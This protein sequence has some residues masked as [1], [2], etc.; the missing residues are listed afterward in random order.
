MIMT[1]FFNVLTNTLCSNV[2]GYIIIQMLHEEFILFVII[3]ELFY[4]F[5]L[6]S[7]V[8]CLST[9]QSQLNSDQQYNNTKGNPLFTLRV[10]PPPRIGM[11]KR[12]PP[13]SKSSLPTIPMTLTALTMAMAPP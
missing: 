11:R 7:L 9:F 3:C 13:P 1:F 4:C 6:V 10:P 2:K 5:N 12:P 8:S